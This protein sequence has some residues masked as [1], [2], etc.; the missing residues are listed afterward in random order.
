MGFS[1]VF[2]QPSWFLG[3]LQRIMAQRYKTAHE[4]LKA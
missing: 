3:Q 4:D 2:D 1:R